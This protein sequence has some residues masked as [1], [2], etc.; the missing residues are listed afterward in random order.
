MITTN[1]PSW[2]EGAKS[3]VRAGFPAWLSSSKFSG[4]SITGPAAS[5]GSLGT[6]TD[7]KSLISLPMLQAGAPQIVVDAFMGTLVNAVSDWLSSIRVPGL[8]WYPGFAA[9]SAPMAPPTPNAPCYVSSLSQNLAL[10]DAAT[11]ATAIKAAFGE[12]ASGPG[13]NDGINEFCAWFNS[14]FKTLTS[15][16]AIQNVMGTGPVPGFRPPTVPVAPV[17]NGYMIAGTGSTVA[18]AW[19]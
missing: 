10:I 12:A 1:W 14:G 17:I 3:G 5:N 9:V 11:L 18:P 4:I 19:S 13:G 6:S 7:L 15:K 8:P 2:S 16:T